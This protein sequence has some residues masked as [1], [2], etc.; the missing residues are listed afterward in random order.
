[1]LVFQDLPTGYLVL[2]DVADDRTFATWKAVVDARLTAL[3][4]EVLYLVSDRAKALIQL[5]EQGLE[6]LSMPDFFHCMHDL[7]KSY[8]CAHWPALATRA[9]ELN[10]SPGGPGTTPG[11]PQA[12]H[13]DPEAQALVEARQAEVTRLGRG[14][15]HVSGPLGDPL[16]HA[17][18]LPHRGLGSPD[19]RPGRKPTAG[20]GGG[21]RS[22]RPAPSVAGPA[23]R[24][25][26]GPQAGACPRRPGGLLVA[27]RPA[28]FGA[29]HP[30]AHVEEWVHECLLPLVYW[31]HQAA[32]TRCARRKAK[33]RQALEAVHA[34]FH[35]HAITTAAGPPGA[36]GVESMGRPADEG[37]SADLISRGRAQWLFVANASEPSGLAQAQIQGV[38]DLT[39][40]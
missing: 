5:A 30:L 33:I 36:G 28:G 26:Q 21:D 25:D 16:A 9:Q 38:D 3:G 35:T 19:L 8:S 23:R 12:E 39:Q 4:T 34:T 24:H 10:E 17:A 7:V 31:E 27:R 11:A 32:H 18:S 1:M 6:C 14:A 15:Q 40:L 20:D 29:I 22:V 13:A 37:L 2:E